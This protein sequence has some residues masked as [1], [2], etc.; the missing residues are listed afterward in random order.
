MISVVIFVC[1]PG[2]TGG[3]LINSSLTKPSLD[4]VR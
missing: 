4:D 2:N 3:V 1:A